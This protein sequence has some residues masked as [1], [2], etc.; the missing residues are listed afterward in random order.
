MKKIFYTAAFALLT[1]GVAQA[2]EKIEKTETVRTTV[3]SSLGNET[4][5]KTTKE[6]QL[7]P[8]KNCPRTGRSGKSSP[9][10]R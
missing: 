1:V 4:V 3:K 7:T 8:V 9:R 5:Y 6:T 10:A 2:Q